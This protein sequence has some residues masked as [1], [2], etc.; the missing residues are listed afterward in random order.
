LPNHKKVIFFP[1]PPKWS[2]FDCVVDGRNVI[3]EWYQGLSED[4]Q[5]TF[6]ALLKN[7]QKVE[8]VLGWT[9]FK[10]LQGKP[11]EE[12][13][14]QLDFI[15]D[16]RQ[17]RLLGVFG[18][19]RRNAVMLLGCYHKGPVYTPQDSLEMAR[20]RAKA[21]REGKAATHERKIKSDS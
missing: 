2:F 7:Q 9:G 20:K 6:D 4:A 11:K 12:R 8:S 17:Y 3:E 19:A 14:W 18:Q 1:S 21:L 10:Y 15:A 5:F 13:I 16:K